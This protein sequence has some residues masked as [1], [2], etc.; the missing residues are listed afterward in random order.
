MLR[1]KFPARKATAA[2]VVAVSEAIPKPSNLYPAGCAGSRYR[3]LVQCCRKLDVTLI[4]PLV[5][6]A[7]LFEPPPQPLPGQKKCPRRPPEKGSRLPKLSAVLVNPKTVWEKISVEWYDGQMR[8]LEI[9]T[10]TA[11]WKHAWLKP[12]PIRWSLVRAPLGEL[13]RK[14]A[15]HRSSAGRCQ[16]GRGVCPALND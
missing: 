10:G 12:L 16:H 6:D 13:D 14:P 3:H 7:Q 5:L 2:T 15:H 8:V 4:A 11:L 9:I 1:P